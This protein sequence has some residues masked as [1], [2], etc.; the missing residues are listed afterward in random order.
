MYRGLM[1]RA[2]M[3]LASSL[4]FLMM[5]GSC[6]PPLVLTSCADIDAGACYSNADCTISQHCTWNPQITNVD[7]VAVTCCVPGAR[8]TGA[9]GAMCTSID[10]CA[11][12]VCVYTTGGQYCSMKCTGGPSVPDATCPA[13]LPW[14]VF[15]N[16]VDAGLFAADAGVDGGGID[17]GTFCGLA[18]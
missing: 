10:D 9:A 13:T 11:S 6:T 16:P 1:T 2:F 4:V 17:A 7:L 5:D 14:C 3:P 8:G 15:V 12:G 18:P